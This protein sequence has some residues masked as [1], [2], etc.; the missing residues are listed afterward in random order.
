MDSVRK[1]T[2][3]TAHQLAWIVLFICLACLALSCSVYRVQH[4]ETYDGAGNMTSQNNGIMK[5]VPFGGRDIS[6][7]TLSLD[8]LSANKYKIQLGENGQT[9]LTGTAAILQSAM[10]QISQLSSQLGQAQMLNQALSQQ[11][12]QMRQP[13][14]PP[15]ALPQK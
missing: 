3:F 5:V 14:P 6:A 7:G 10:A 11:L 4:G 1:Q 12:Q 2:R 15:A 9:D 8:S 13:A